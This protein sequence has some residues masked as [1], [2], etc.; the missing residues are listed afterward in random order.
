MRPGGG[1]VVDEVIGRVE[2]GKLLSG[3]EQTMADINL[4]V[5][6][7]APNCLFFP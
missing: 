1:G 7:A 6:K 5:R 4:V 3:G 2:S